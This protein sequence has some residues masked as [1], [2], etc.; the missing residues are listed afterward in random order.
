[1]LLTLQCM[2]I[3]PTSLD[4]C[5]VEQMQTQITVSEHPQHQPHGP[6]TVHSKQLTVWYTS[7]LNVARLLNNSEVRHLVLVKCNSAGDELLPFDHF[8]VRRLERLS[9]FWRPEQSQDL[10]LGRDMGALYH[11]EARIAV[12]QAAVLTGKAKLKAFT[13]KTKVDSQGMMSF[14]NVFMSHDGLPEMASMFVT[15]VY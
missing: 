6:T 3:H 7:S 10:V 1:M 5:D 15:F 8:T 9:V 2:Y 11:E 4:L 14:P 13:V 12:I